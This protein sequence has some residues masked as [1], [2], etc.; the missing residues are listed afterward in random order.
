[1]IEASTK[2]KDPSALDHAAIMLPKA[3]AIVSSCEKSD[4]VRYMTKKPQKPEDVK[5]E[6]GATGR[7]LKGVNK[8]LKTPPTPFTPRKD[9]QSKSGVTTGQKSK[10]S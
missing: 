4:M 5:D 3:V 1:M 10:E 8:A 7:F 2:I 9:E 6:P